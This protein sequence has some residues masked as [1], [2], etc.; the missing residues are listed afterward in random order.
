MSHNVGSGFSWNI[1]V[2]SLHFILFPNIKEHQ[3]PTIMRKGHKT[4]QVIIQLCMT[5]LLVPFCLVVEKSRFYKVTFD[6]QIIL[7]FA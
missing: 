6:L 3:M 1:N 4:N 5:V 7:S 2:K